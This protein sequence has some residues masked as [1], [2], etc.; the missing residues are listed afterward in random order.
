MHERANEQPSKKKLFD[1]ILLGTAREQYANISPEQAA[2]KLL[3]V[4]LDRDFLERAQSYFLACK[5]DNETFPLIDGQLMNIMSSQ[6]SRD[7]KYYAVIRYLRVLGHSI[8]YVR[9]GI[10]SAIDE[11]DTLT[12]EEKAM[13]KMKVLDAMQSVA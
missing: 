11:S 4:F 3:P 12:D 8:G 9:L 13:E 7:L 1:D 6:V 10:E 5:A 2:K